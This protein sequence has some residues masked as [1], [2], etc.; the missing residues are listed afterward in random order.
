MPDQIQLSVLR[1][2]SFNYEFHKES[3]LDNRLDFKLPLLAV[4]VNLFFKCLSGF[5]SANRIGNGFS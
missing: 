1:I 5:I 4:T 3:G 2:P